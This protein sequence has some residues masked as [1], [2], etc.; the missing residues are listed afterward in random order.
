MTE[1]AATNACNLLGGGVGD[2]FDKFNGCC[3]SAISTCN[4][5]NCCWDCVDVGGNVVADVTDTGDDCDCDD[6]DDDGGGV[7]GVVVVAVPVIAAHD[8]G[9]VVVVVAV[10]TIVVVK[11]QLFVVECGD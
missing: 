1:A 4:S 9:G 8:N 5:N 11:L 7:G 10:V 6:D 2:F 3:E